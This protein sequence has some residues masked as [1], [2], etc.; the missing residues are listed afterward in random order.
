[1]NDDGGIKSL[2]FNLLYLQLLLVWGT[3]D[4]NQLHDEGGEHKQKTWSKPDIHQGDIWRALQHRCKHS[5]T[6]NVHYETHQSRGQGNGQLHC[7]EANR[8]KERR[9]GQSHDNETWEHDCHDI[10]AGI[11]SQYQANLHARIGT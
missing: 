2:I 7:Q 9:P 11:S 10:A 1:M 4:D 3:G 6:E 5:T 8:N